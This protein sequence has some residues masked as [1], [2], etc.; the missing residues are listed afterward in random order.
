MEL[1]QRFFGGGEHLSDEGV[2]LYVDA[3]RLKTVSQLPSSVRDH[4]AEC[5]ECKKSVTGLFTLL[6]DTD[7]SDVESHPFFTVSRAAGSRFSFLMKIAAV[8]VGILSLATLSYLV[9][10]FR[11]REVTNG[12]SQEARGGGMDTS[13]ESHTGAK[14]EANE[15]FAANFAASPNLDDFVNDRSRSKEFVVLSP[16]NG[17]AVG[18]NEIF[19]WRKAAG[20]LHTMSILDNKGHTVVTGIA[21]DSGYA[22]KQRLTPGLYYWKL[23]DESEL[24]YVGKFIVK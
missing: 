10:P 19:R 18:P 4:V 9:G 24:L 21:T 7:Y 22:L 13:R 23:E 20:T 6:D 8:V 14:P 1:I 12:T 2:A 15:D 17:A 5:R 3:L 11:P 16:G